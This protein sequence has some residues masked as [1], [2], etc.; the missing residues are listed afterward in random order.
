MGIFT[1]CS[2]ILYVKQL[3]E[4]ITRR[5]IAHEKKTLVAALNLYTCIY[6]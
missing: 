6:P 4:K 5:L 2:D 1:K 3:I